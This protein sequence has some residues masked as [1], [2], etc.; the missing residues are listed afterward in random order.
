VLSGGETERQS[1]GE[2]GLAAV[3]STL[4]TLLRRWRDLAN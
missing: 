2:T 1:G 4:R 3:I